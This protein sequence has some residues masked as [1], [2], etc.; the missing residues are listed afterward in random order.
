MAPDGVFGDGTDRG[1]TQAVLLR[2]GGEFSVVIAGQSAQRSDPQAPV[3]GSPERSDAIAGQR[4][5]FFVEDYEIVTVKLR[6][7]SSVPSHK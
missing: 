1:V 7:P 5:V 6:Q 2:E 4:A 3:F